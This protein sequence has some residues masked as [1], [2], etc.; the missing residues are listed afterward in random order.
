MNIIEMIMS[1][2]EPIRLKTGYYARKRLLHRG[3][4][5]LTKVNDMYY[6]VAYVETLN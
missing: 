2:L 4:E 3:Y 5:I 1:N 6:R